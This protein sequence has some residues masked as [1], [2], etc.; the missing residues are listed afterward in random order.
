MD[1]FNEEEEVEDAEDALR[2]SN[3]EFRLEEEEVD[4]GARRSPESIS[5]EGVEDGNC[6]RM[7]IEEEEEGGD[8]GER[9]SKEKAQLRLKRS[10]SG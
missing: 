2:L 7:P 5:R 9:G 4:L 10:F 3:E 8:T 6:E 1:R